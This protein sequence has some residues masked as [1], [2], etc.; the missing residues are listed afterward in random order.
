MYLRGVPDFG[1]LLYLC[2]APDLA[3]CLVL[4]GLANGLESTPFANCPHQAMMSMV[5]LPGSAGQT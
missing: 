1:I 2:G 3:H 4:K 5:I